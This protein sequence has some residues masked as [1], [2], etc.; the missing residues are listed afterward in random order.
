[1]VLPEPDYGHLMVAMKAQC[2]LLNLQPT[3][4]FLMK[5]IQ[6][7]EMVVVRHGLMTVGQPFSGKTAS[8][9]VPARPCCAPAGRMV[10]HAAQPCPWHTPRCT[11]GYVS[12]RASSCSG[13][14]THAAA[15][16]NA[17]DQINYGSKGDVLC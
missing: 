16:C 10:P 2:A 11:C 7:Y 17:F 13:Q 5:T 9:K 1:M 4:Y 14:G 12:V 6:L 15:L 3:E 8:L